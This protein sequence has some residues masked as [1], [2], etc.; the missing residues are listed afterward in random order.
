M[1]SS[2]APQLL[3]L[4][5]VLACGPSAP[6]ETDAMAFMADMTA[7][8]E[9][10]ADA[11]AFAALWA[12]DGDFYNLSTATHWRGRAAVDSAMSRVFQRR[13]PAARVELT[14]DRIRLVEPGLALVDAT[15]SQDGAAT[16]RMSLV[17]LPVEGDWRIVAA[18]V[19]RAA[20]D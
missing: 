5:A 10:G 13:N 4:A 3:V 1:R 7:I 2:A 16:E 17:L 15:L 14:T 8:Y 20:V 9:A 6:D 11:T 18:R 19:A 12:D